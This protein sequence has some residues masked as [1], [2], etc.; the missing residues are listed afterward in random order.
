MLLYGFGPF[1]LDV[2]ER[3][4]TCDG[5]NV[6]LR[7]KVFDTLCA[8]VQNP[9]RL[10]RK[11]ELLRA[12]WPDTIVEENN[13]D[14]CVSQ[15]RKA[16]GTDYQYIET[17]PRQGYRFTAEVKS[18][19]PG[20]HLV[21]TEAKPR[22]ETEEMQEVHSFTTSD[23]VRLSYA[24]G[25]HGPV[26]VRAVDWINHLDF[27]WSN[28]YRRQWFSRIMEHNTLLRYDQR[29][30]GLSDWNVV[31]FSFERS[32][33]DFE[34]L[35]DHLGYKQI[36]IYGSCQ[37]G[38]IATAYAAKHPERVSKLILIG[39]IASG[40]PPPGE[41]VEEQFAALLTLVRLGWGKDNPAFRQLWTTLF[42]PDAGAEEAEYLNEL[43][44]ITASP[45]NA[46]LMLGEFRKI[47][48]V[49][50]LPKVSCPTLIVHSRDDAVVPVKE[51]RLLASRIRNSRLVELPSRSHQVGPEE[52]CW[53]MFLDE[54]VRFMQ[55]DTPLKLV[56][57]RARKIAGQ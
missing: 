21:R 34:E 3:L 19:E 20:P 38:S 8:L 29:G 5:N 54:F 48:V 4:L 12:V 32:V 40:W 27:E 28:P 37:G 11:D 1:L 45:E 44:R 25:G 55:W 47:D 14:Y 9:G 35:I 23:G 10:V 39:S 17:V 22:I 53:E 7:G 51:G 24:V 13:L 50:L 36:S 15:L 41:M 2:Q 26:M 52:P 57:A 30:S 33:K 43:Q 31:D 46:A 18:I 49:D 16:F 42:K 56:S 6:R